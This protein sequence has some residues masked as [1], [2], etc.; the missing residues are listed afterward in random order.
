MIACMQWVKKVDIS[1][2]LDELKYAIITFSKVAKREVTERFAVQ[3]TKLIK[4]N[5]FMRGRMV[6]KLEDL[7]I[8]EHSGLKYGIEPQTAKNLLKII[9][10][11]DTDL[12]KAQP[13]QIIDYLKNKLE[14]EMDEDKKE[15]VQN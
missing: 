10:N 15:E 6:A 8:L 3:A 4:A 1:P 9:I 12:L 5:A 2:I 7:D 11:S 13:A 14:L